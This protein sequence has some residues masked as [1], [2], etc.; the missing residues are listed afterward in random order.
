MLI[1]ENSAKVVGDAALGKKRP[2]GKGGRARDNRKSREGRG[3]VGAHQK[4]IPNLN[5]GRGFRWIVLQ[6]CQIV[7][8]TDNMGR[9][10]HKEKFPYRGKTDILG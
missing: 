10:H 8:Q 4:K 1:L 3:R 6:S 9:Y 2:I 7:H 5:R